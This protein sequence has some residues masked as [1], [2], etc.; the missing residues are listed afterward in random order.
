[1]L[2]KTLLRLAVGICLGL[3]IQIAGASDWKTYKATKYGFSMLVPNGVKIAEREWP[4]GWGGFTAESEGVK[5][6]AQAK[7]GAQESD[8]AIE[9]YAVGVTSVPAAAWRKIDSGTNQN[10][11]TRFR[12][13]EAK[14]G[15][16][17]HFGGYGVGKK[18]NYLFF[19]QTTVSDYN[20]NKAEYQK[21]YDSL[22]LD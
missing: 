20:A 3:V 15:N 13:F 10:G 11:W 22:R 21:W 4:G 16:T 17:L 14:Q 7:L 1:M 18:G 6:T 2:N 9:K 8:A 12:A 5:L 19:M